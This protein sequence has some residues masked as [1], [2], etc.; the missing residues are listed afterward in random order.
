M[1]GYTNATGLD[2]VDLRVSYSIER[3]RINTAAASVSFATNTSATSNA[4]TDQSS[5][6]STITY[7]TGTSAYGFGPL[8]TTNRTGTLSNINLASSSAL[9]FQWLFNTTGGN[10]QGLGL[11]DVILRATKLAT[12]GTDRTVTALGGLSDTVLQNG[13][14]STASILTAN[15]SA[16]ETFAGL[17]QNGGTAALGLTKSGAN[18]L[19]L[20]NANTYTGPTTISGGTLAL[21]S[22]GSI[23]NS[24][25]IAI[26]SGATFDV[27]AVT[28]GYALA[29][30]QTLTGAGT[31]TGAMTI[32]SGATLS[33]GNS[34]GNLSMGATTFG[35]GGN[36]NWQMFDTSLT[37]GTGWDL[38]SVTGDLTVTATSGDKFN[39]NLWSLSGVGPDVNGDALNFDS[40]SNYAWKIA[41][42]TGNIVDFSA[43]K[44][45]IN[46]AAINGTAGF[47]NSL[48]GGTFSIAQS[49]SDLNLIFTAA[50]TGANLY[51]DGGG[52]WTT[53]APGAGGVGTWANA[54]GGWDPDKIANFAGTAAA[55]TVGTATA[56]K[57]L[58]FSADGYALSGGTLTLSAVGADN[59]ITVGS[60]MTTTL[61]TLLSTDAGLIKSGAGNLI[62]DT[63]QTYTGGTLVSSGT[64]TLGHATNT[65]NDAEAVT[66]SGTLALGGNSDT[67]GSFA[68]TGG[69]LTGTGTLSAAT[70]ALNGGTVSANLGSGSATST[71]GTTSLVGTFAGN[72][73]VSGGTVNLGAS[74]RLAN[75]S[76]LVI[77]S[78]TLGLGAFDETVGSFTI[79]GG[80][81]G[82]TGTL[83]SGS[84]YALEGGTVSANL[85]AGTTTATTGTTALNGTLAGPLTVS[86]GTV[87]LGASNRLSDSS[88][89][90]ITSGSL[91]LGSFDDTVSSFSISGG[92][93][94]GTG[95]LT[96]TSGYT[97]SGGTVSGNLGTGT[98]TA[99]TGS[100]SLAGTLAGDLTLNGGTVTLASADRLGNGSA[101]SISSGSLD[102]GT[103]NDTV[104]SFTLTG[105]SLA[106]STGILTAATYAL[107]GGTV[108]ARLGGGAVT[109]STGT[110]TLG[111]AGRLAPFSNLEIASG[112]L[113]LGGNETV[114]SYT[115]SP[116]ATLGGSGV[117]TAATYTLNGGT[118]NSGAGLGAGA[119]TAGSGSTALNGTLEGSLAVTGGTVTLGSPERIGDSSAVSVSAGSLNLGGNADTVG[120]VTLSGGTIENGTLNG[121]SYALSG[122]TLA[123]S[124]TGAGPITAASGT[125][126]INGSNAAFIGP[127][128]VSGGTL[129]LATD[130]A[131]GSSAIS[132]TSG[133]VFAAS[134]VTNSNSI[135][136]GTAAGT[137]NSSFT[138]VW[139]FTTASPSSSDAIGFTISA[140]TQ[141][142]NNGTTTLISSISPSNNYSGASGSNNAGAAAFLGSLNTATSTFFAFTLTPT[143]A[144]S[145]S[146]NDVSF[147]SRS[148]STGPQAYTIRDATDL[149]TDLSSGT[150]LANSTWALN[151]NAFT[152]TLIDTSGTTFRIYGYNGA[153]SPAA[154]TANWRIDDLR[155]SGVSTNTVVA[156]GTGTLGITEA[157]SAT[158]TGPITV[159]N[160]ATLTAV[161]GG[162]ASF[163][164]V[165]SGAGSVSKTGAGIVALSPASTITGGFTLDE[166]TLLVTNTSGSATGS[167]AFTAAAGTTLA[168]TG[169]IAPAADTAINLNG[170]L[171][172]GDTTLGSPVASVFELATSGTG[173]TITGSSSLFYFDLFSNLGN[174]SLNSSS[175]A[176]YIRLFG[177]L[178]NSAGGTLII[179]NPLALNNFSLGDAWNLFDLSSGGSITN[180]FDLDFSSL[181]LDPSLYE[182]HFDRTT[183]VFSIAN[184][185]PEPSRALLTALGLTTLLFR[186]RRA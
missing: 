73:T 49:G 125:T 182:G 173:S 52:N 116:G 62:F 130:T 80:T 162:T 165:I 17:L 141:S 127:T 112:Q 186:R 6:F 123:A 51:W 26:A 167:G 155:L 28:G 67:V 59:V 154:N 100:T 61:S 166:G 122:G 159:N 71:S 34:P 140:L 180:D 185:I 57:G 75:G 115:Q 98:A 18:I 22:S 74:E 175:S 108:N 169:R 113:D 58:I 124:L 105:G 142:N 138:I 171:Y 172:V 64:L 178:G 148:T 82:G 104:G 55:V 137:A 158:F 146:L 63:T 14:N 132:L 56:N 161:A 69:S 119:A 43:D 77:S 179:G 150:L 84:G 37:A 118:I 13:S 5:T 94:T 149:S 129:S 120:A 8:D 136:I 72:L 78:G 92:S 183:G 128:T 86:G 134:G 88:A 168:G 151:S 133:S 68:L 46:V 111:S 93:L 45:A 23:N 36:Y 147:G 4:W 152:N 54:T 20:T 131:L 99:S 25:S 47:S 53:T 135:T 1:V 110:T 70:Y 27:S 101:V 15:L 66:V 153:G 164:N 41:T 156:S 87:N 21:G 79:S 19:T 117:L 106:G 97:L 24:S 85:G 91:G 31:V 38:L 33:P 163:T 76:S 50:D 11:D 48:G 114:A 10:S 35:S 107:Q 60:G 90:A 145:V 177:T 160:T 102:I 7:T 174:G 65:L 144:S 39:L 89:V 40:A 103:F 170:N 139:D 143:S 157:G 30:G 95:T 29:S 176:D 109:V 83:T 12:N 81:L 42:A 96:S 44:F 2:I 181:G 3:Y 121:S 184:A 126:L 9:Y 32:A 16:S